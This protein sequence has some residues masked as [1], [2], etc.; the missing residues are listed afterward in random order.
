MFAT[1]V[2]EH[3]LHRVERRKPDE[4]HIVR[5]AARLILE[6]LHTDHPRRHVAVQRL[7]RGWVMT[8]LLVE[9]FDSLDEHGAVLDGAI[10]TPGGRG[11]QRKLGEQYEQE[12]YRNECGPELQAMRGRAVTDL[13]RVPMETPQQSGSNRCEEGAKGEL[14]DGCRFADRHAQDQAPDKRGEESRE[15]G[16]A[17]RGQPRNPRRQK[18]RAGVAPN[19]RD[20]RKGCRRCIEPAGEVRQ[21]HR[22][23]N[24]DEYQDAS[25]HSNAPLSA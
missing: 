4:V 23:W 25:A 13:A 15:P 17:E 14:I 19:L 18:S 11:R 2:V 5:V 12:G 20:E 6:P 21:C 22:E 9:G 24:G 7:K 16:L 1:W 10:A 3:D 8:A